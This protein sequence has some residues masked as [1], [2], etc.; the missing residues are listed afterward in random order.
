MATIAKHICDKCKK[1]INLK[2]SKYIYCEGDCKKFW[3]LSKC[4]NISD[5]KLKLINENP[6]IPWFCDPC[7]KKKKVKRNTL[8]LNLSLMGSTSSIPDTPTNDIVNTP[9]LSNVTLEMIYDELRGIK[10]N[11]KKIQ[12]TINNLEM[13]M[14]DY[15]VIIDNLTE[16]NVELR[17]QQEILSAKINHLE[18]ARDTDKQ[19]LLNKNIII[20]GVIEEKDENG[21][22]IMEK[23]AESC[24]VDIDIT[25]IKKVYRMQTQNENTG[26]GRSL[27]VEFFDKEKKN[28]IIKNS[29]NKKITMMSINPETNNDRDIYIS[30]QLTSRRQFLHKLAR[31]KKKMKIIEFVWISEGE[32]LIRKQSGSPA[33]KIKYKHQLDRL[34]N[35]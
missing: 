12:E 14:N 2:T 34:S 7:L 27:L 18:Y 4:I 22:K 3:H 10:N 23:I 8:N 32:I 20:N 24:N 33:I 30:E 21:F 35:E 16:E 15:R 5:E 17:N 29:R 26:M 28:A 9:T 6:D 11:Q 1:N 25:H 31:D 13:T 19:Q